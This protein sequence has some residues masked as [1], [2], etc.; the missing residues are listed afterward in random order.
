M[1][2]VFFSYPCN[3]GIDL[4]SEKPIAAF[5]L[6]SIESWGVKIIEESEQRF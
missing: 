1:N 5:E 4:L 2:T 6:L 3:H